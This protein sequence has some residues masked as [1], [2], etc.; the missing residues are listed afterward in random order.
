MRD[1]DV[2]NYI[3][4]TTTIVCFLSS[5]PEC[6]S[7]PLRAAMFVAHVALKVP[8]LLLAGVGFHTTV[9][10]PQPPP[11][12]DEYAPSV[13]LESFI[14]QRSAPALVKVRGVHALL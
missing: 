14:R 12:H 3:K 6:L 11:A 9:T 5:G 8:L 10:P 7:F 1:F 13:H 2:Y 4:N